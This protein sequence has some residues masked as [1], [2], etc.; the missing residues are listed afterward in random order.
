MDELADALT[1]RTEQVVVNRTNLSGQFDVDLF[2]SSGPLRT[3]DAGAGAS[4]AS[5]DDKPVLSVAIQEQL[6][7]KLVSRPEPLDV[8][9]I[10]HIERP[11]DN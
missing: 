9:V 2:W 1:N 5:P 4:S 11:S 10:D 8:L 7:L 6:G 3:G